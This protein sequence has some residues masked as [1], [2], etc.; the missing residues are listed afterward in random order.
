MAIVFVANV[1]PLQAQ[2]IPLQAP[3][4]AS[5]WVRGDAASVRLVAAKTGTSGEDAVGLGLEFMLDPG[6]KTYWRSPGDAG[7]PPQVL[8]LIHI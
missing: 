1:I 8:S 5:D 3:E 4:G 2:E 7:L 6:W